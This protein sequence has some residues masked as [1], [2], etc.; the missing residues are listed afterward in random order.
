MAA[1]DRADD[2]PLEDRTD[3]T[4]HR[5]GAQDAEQQKRE[6]EPD[7]IR[8]RP[9]GQGTEHEERG[10]GAER[11]ED[12]VAEIDDVH[13]AEDE[14]EARGHE[15]DHHAH[16]EPGDGERHP[17]RGAADEGQRQ[18]RKGRNEEQREPVHL[19][20]RQLGGGRCISGHVAH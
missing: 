2:H 12:A 13:Q 1:I 11:D 8:L 20:A 5:H 19:G 7:G 18:E 4:R 10:V 15:K 14:G 3:K 16:G 6:I 17:G 9:S